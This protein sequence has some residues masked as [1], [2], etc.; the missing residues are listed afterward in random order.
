MMEP[1]RK[2][3]GGT[4]SK[5]DLEFVR[6]GFDEY[7]RGTILFCHHVCPHRPG[8]Q[9]ECGDCPVNKVFHAIRNEQLDIDEMLHWYESKQLNEEGLE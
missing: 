3:G 9:P 4:F 6:I 8:W 5:S 2:A 1:A 7:Q